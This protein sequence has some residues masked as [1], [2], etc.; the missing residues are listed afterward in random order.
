VILFDPGATTTRATFTFTTV[1]FTGSTQTGGDDLE[2]VKF[3]FESFKEQ[4]GPTSFGW[5]VA[6][7]KAA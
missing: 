2:H 5:N 7:N 6:Q 4:I 3:A 1:F